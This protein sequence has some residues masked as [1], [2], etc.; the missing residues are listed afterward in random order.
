MAAP[1]QE[2]SLKTIFMQKN[3][4]FKFKIKVKILK[5]I[6][7]T[8]FLVADS[9]GSCKLKIDNLKPIYM[10]SFKENNFVKIFNVKT[11]IIEKHIIVDCTSKVFLIG[12]F[13]IDLKKAPLETSKTVVTIPPKT[14]PEKDTKIMSRQQVAV[15]LKEVFEMK[16]WSKR[17]K[18]TVKILKKLSENEFLVADS[19]TSRKIK[20]DNLKPIYM[21][22]LEEN[23]FV[24]ILDAQ[25]N[26]ASMLVILDHKSSVF[27]IPKFEKVHDPA[28]VKE[29]STSQNNLQYKIPKKVFE[30]FKKR[31][32]LKKV[33]TLAFLVGFKIDDIITVTHIVFGKQNAFKYK[34]YDDGK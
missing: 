19:T 7:S 21:A 12:R 23:N 28:N 10:G 25:V 15:P 9:T 34:V 32:N 11:N 20:I 33:Q 18:F 14:I 3:D 1:I 6:S 30:E 26:V 24:K 2:A 4:G 8:D 5:T 31:A 29:K 27:N 16:N 22:N 13:E 17:L